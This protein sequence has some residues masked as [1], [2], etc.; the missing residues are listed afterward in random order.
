VKLLSAASLTAAILL[1]PSAPA[2][3]QTYPNRVVKM[4]VP[5]GPAGPTDLLGRLVAGALS[6]S[7]GQ[8]F[9]IEN[10]GGG[11]LG[12]KAAAVAPA[13]GY[14]LLVGNT[15]TLANIPAVS[16]NW[17][18]MPRRIRASSTMPQSGPAI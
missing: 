13:D 4:I 15:A 11:G 18:P 12:A 2:S 6:N 9:I 1:A 17:W 3:A 7:L 10:R 16:R 5:A 8:S 14:T